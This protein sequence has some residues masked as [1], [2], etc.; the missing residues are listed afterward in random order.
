MRTFP[1][2]FYQEMFRLRG[3]EFPAETPQK[4]RYFGLLTDDIVYDGLAPGVSEEL[5]KAN[6]KDEVTGRRKHKNFPWLANNIGCPKLREHL[7]AVIATMK[8]N[9][10]W[11]DFKIKLDRNYPR[12][13]KPTQLSMDLAD[14]EP[15]T[16]K[17]L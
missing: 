9:A 11:H 2:D 3:M 16:G 13:G 7:G 14:D 5:K 6:P 12:Q 1:T 17:G 10:G 15:E 4:P 8:L